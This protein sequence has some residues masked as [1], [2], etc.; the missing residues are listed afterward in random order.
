[1]ELR[2]LGQ[3]Y[4]TSNYQVDTIASE[5]TGHFRGHSYTL[6]R[7]RQTFKSQLGVRKYRG[8]IYGAQ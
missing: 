6:R 4:S 3:A 8:V 1:M 7:P 2:F 5:H